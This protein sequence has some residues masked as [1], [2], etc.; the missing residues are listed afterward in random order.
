MRDIRP[1]IFPIIA[2]SLTLVGAPCISG[3]TLVSSFRMFPL[4]PLFF[5][6][7]LCYSLLRLSEVK[8]LASAV[9][10]YYWVFPRGGFFQFSTFRSCI[11][12]E[13]ALFVVEPESQP[14]LFFNTVFSYPPPQSWKRLVTCRWV[15][16][17]RFTRFFF[18]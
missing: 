14:P 9:V 16:L 13:L 7:S 5:C 1:C 17:L 15:R 18:F 8:L 12:P 11:L 3:Q 10:I 4:S 6:L 2:R